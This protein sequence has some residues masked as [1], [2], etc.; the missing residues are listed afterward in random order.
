[1]LLAPYT[2]TYSCPSITLPTVNC[3]AGIEENSKNNLVLS[4]WPNPVINSLHLEITNS[5]SEFI[6]LKI[7]NQL[8]ENVLDLPKWQSS[9]KEISLENLTNGV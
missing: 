8:G 4:I 2:T 7:T 5:Q 6:D 1:M 3:F 9:K